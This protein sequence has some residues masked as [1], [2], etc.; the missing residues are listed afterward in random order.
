MNCKHLLIF[1]LALLPQFLF[2]CQC[3]G[4]SLSLEEISKYEIIFL[5]KIETVKECGDRYGEAVFTVSELY[6]GNATE[7]FKLLFTCDDP[8]AHKFLPGEEWIIYSRY[9]QIDN[10]LMDWCSRSRKFF[11]FDVQD[12]YLVNFGNTYE[13]E[14]EFLRKELGLHRLLTTTSNQS[15][16]RNVRPDKSQMVWVL[17]ASLA[18]IILFY[19]LFNRFFK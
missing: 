2:P 15:A 16:D 5:G 11:R 13:E 4:T 14:R 18:G 9:K 6:K 10:A 3:P 7:K 12:L 17:L 1:F 8:C 19:F